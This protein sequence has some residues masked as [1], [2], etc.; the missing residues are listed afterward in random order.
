MLTKEDNE[1]IT[2]CGPGTP[3]GNLMR[4]Y[5]I[6]A[7]L[8]QELPTPDCA[9]IRVRL[10]NENLIAFRV[11]SGK[12]GLIDDYCPHRGASMFFGRNAEDGLRCIYHGWKFDVTGTCTD[13]MT[14]PPESKLKDKVRAVAYPTEERNGIIWAYLG[15]RSEPPPLPEFEANMV[16][17]QQ[18][19]LFVT[20]G[21][22]NWLQAIENNMDTSHNAILHHGTVRPED[23]AVLGA[24]YFEGPDVLRWMVSDRAPRFDIR[25]TD[26]GAASAAYRTTDD[27]QTYWRTMNW[28]WPFYT[29][30]PT[31]ELGS[32]AL[33][34]ATVPVDD[35]HCMIFGLIARV[36]PGRS[37]YD[38]IET[39][40]YTGTGRPTL[41]NTSD[42]LGRFR[43]PLSL[44]IQNDFGVDR[45]VQRLGPPTVQGMSGIAN[46][47]AQDEAIRWSQGRAGDNGIVDRSREHLGHTD[48]MIT[49]VR[50][51]LLTAAKA[52][53]DHDTVPPAVDAPD[54]YRVRPG[55]TTLPKEI[56]WWEA[57]RD[58]R[59]GFK[60]KSRA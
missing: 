44:E 10:L 31:S 55:W 29:Q 19:K 40:A 45:E 11:T 6:P 20:L 28:L 25:D 17:Q 26:Y 51:K 34:F 30:S 37:M 23:T 7:M 18:A 8:S 56:D 38:S 36:G 50:K 49:R 46:I 39:D 27:G 42:W 2:R 21:N 5:W 43:D 41:P 58:Q 22:Y 3:M 13:M 12:V 53:R 59:E 60:E 15:P 4:Q 47:N 57:T 48:A 52:L 9:P 1:L 14:E 35:N 54:V 33:M 24:N 32:T 16:P